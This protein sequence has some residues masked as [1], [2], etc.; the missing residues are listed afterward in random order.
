MSKGATNHLTAMLAAD[1]SQRDIR[2]RVNA[3]APGTFPSEIIRPYFKGDVMTA[4]EVTK[5]AASLLPLPS[6][7]AGK[8]VSSFLIL[9]AVTDCLIL[10]KGRRKS[11]VL[12]STS[13]L[14]RETIRMARSSLLTAVILLSMS[15]L[16]EKVACV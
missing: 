13:F 5:A 1:F 6:A 8:F 15:P 11:P 9:A 16:V 10:C 4:E 2:V 7:R 3:I 12:L 14:L